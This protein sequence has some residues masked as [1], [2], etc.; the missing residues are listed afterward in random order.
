M[1]TSKDLL[2]QAK[3]TLDSNKIDAGPHAASIKQNRKEISDLQMLKLVLKNAVT[4][5]DHTLTVMN[6][7]LAKLNAG[8]SEL[9]K[10]A[11]VFKAPADA[12]VY[13]Q[14]KAEYTKMIKAGMEVSKA[15]QDLK[16]DIQAALK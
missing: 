2:A 12:K 5:N 15:Y 3:K 13:A 16:K 11:P 14:L 9:N 10:N 1:P 4:A 6:T 7:K 8:L